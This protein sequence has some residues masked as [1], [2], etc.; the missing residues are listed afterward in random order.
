MERINN[1]PEITGIPFVQDGKD[2]EYFE[3][4]NIEVRDLPNGI[5]IVSVGRVVD[6]QFTAEIRADFATGAYNDP[7][8]KPGLHHLGEHLICDPSLEEEGSRNDAKING[9]TSS[10]T[11]TFT[12]DGIANPSV[13]NFGVWPLLTGFRDSLV[14][15]LSH[16]S[17]FDAAIFKEKGVVLRELAERK[18]NQEIQGN[19]FKYKTI[20]AKN[21]PIAI[22]SGGTPKGLSRISRENVEGLIEK[23]LVPDKT[24]VSAFCQGPKGLNIAVA[25]ELAELFSSFPRAGENSQPV[26]RKLL[27]SLNPTFNPQGV[28][29]RRGIS[30]RP[31]SPVELV[32]LMQ[33]EPYSEASCAL[34]RLASALSKKV[35]DYVRDRRI[36]YGGFF[37]FDQVGSTQL[38]YARF[39]LQTTKG[40]VD[41]IKTNLI[42]DIKGIFESVSVSEFEDVI[43]SE[44]LRQLAIPL[45]SQNR[46]VLMINGL[47]EYGK[48]VEA[49]RLK[50]RYFDITPQNLKSL[51]DKL[52]EGQPAVFIL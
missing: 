28:Y 15:P 37:G 52:L 40:M 34:D 35:H 9:V 6:D 42:P 3:A 25:N 17:D 10:T 45:S 31:V 29:I 36:S 50:Q 4:N 12:L 30:R 27:N 13:R 1:A 14:N 51:R 38:C 26:D 48:C 11:Y 20:F 23:A 47:I 49:D 33:G 19:E 46:Y 24:I 43:E 44:R 32:W 7:A 18:S 8:D 22:D 21:N 41:N 16:F 5:K 39:P 2:R